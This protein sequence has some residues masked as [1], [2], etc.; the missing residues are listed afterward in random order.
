MQF[1]PFYG[2][3]TTEAFGE[4]FKKANWH[5]QLIATEPRAQRKGLAT[6]LIK[7]VNRLVCWNYYSCLQMLMEF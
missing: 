1:F 4:G 3:T 7:A 6:A 2:A 5:L